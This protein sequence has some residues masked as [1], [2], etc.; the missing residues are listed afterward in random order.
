M[1]TDSTT[2]N[3]SLP[4]PMRAYLEKRVKLDGF[5]SISDFIRALVREDQKRQAQE[6]LERRLLAALDTSEATPMTAQDW[7][8]IKTAVKTKIASRAKKSK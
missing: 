1:A 3:V 6:E 5:G 2:I 8:E 4:S 7:E